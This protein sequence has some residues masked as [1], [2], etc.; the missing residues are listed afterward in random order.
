MD[1]LSS[2]WKGLKPLVQA[3]INRQARNGGATALASS[4]SGGV[5]A[6]ALY[7]VAHTGTL[8]RTQAPWVATDIASA[9]STHS[10]NLAG[11]TQFNYLSLVSANG[12]WSNSSWGK[13]LGMP[14][15]GYGI[16]WP[17]GGATNA[18]NVGATTTGFYFGT[19]TAD[20]NS[21]TPF[22]PL[23]LGN[24][25]NIAINAGSGA[26]IYNRV[27]GSD[28]TALNDTRLMPSG[29][30]LKDL[31]DYNRKWRTLFAAELYVETLVAQS[32][33]ATIGGRI[34][35][36]PT[37][38]L[39]AD[40]NTSQT[41]I[42]TDYSSF[43]SGDY[44]YFATAPGGIAQ[45][46]VMK[47]TSIPSV[48]TG[49][50]RYTVTRNVDASGANSWVAGDA[51]V[52]LGN[53]TSKG[54]IELTSTS[55]IHNHL[56]PTMAIYSRSATTNWNDVKP[57]VAAGN[58][59]SFVDYGADN[60][61]FATGNDLTLT[62]TTGFKGVTIDRAQGVRLFNTN[63][64][65]Y[66]SGNLFLSMNTAGLT[67]VTQPGSTYADNTSILFK[68][69]DGITKILRL[70]GYEN[71]SGGH[72]GSVELNAGTS[73][74]ILHIDSWA[75]SGKFS[76][77]ELSCK[78]G[79]T[80]RQWIFKQLAD[81]TYGA[82]FSGYL[83]TTGNAV[84]G[85]ENSSVDGRLLVN[86]VIEI[87]PQLAQTYRGGIEVD[88]SS[89]Y[90]YSNEYYSGGWQLYNAAKAPAKIQIVSSSADSS[91]GFYTKAANTAQSTLAGN[92]DKNGNFSVTGTIKTTLNTT[93][94]LGGYTVTAPSATGYVTVKIGGTTYK[95]LA[96]T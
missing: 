19:N 49:G 94:D 8:D 77:I 85:N 41:T 58:L 35:V 70:T 61:G 25:G 67:Y 39:I 75:P 18:W 57:V 14:G 33:L 7:G 62:P 20:D 1:S 71:V 46:E 50:Y 34:I 43:L 93:W 73:D 81:G 27:N 37:A 48:I 86:G 79:S 30:I 51:G 44:L 40:V 21:L 53:S 64:A 32:V 88:S 74:T 78:V 68:E 52:S 2:V 63:I 82:D 91:I 76:N 45:V 4:P 26:A 28:V 12:A 84:I 65:Q 10:A 15:Q 66:D 92:F 42:D 55:T 16:F 54:Y 29:S 72:E 31:G 89:T 24:D 9:I 90:I 36:A 56:G 69:S 11:H 23:A 47:V 87:A 95:L 13:A 38:K 5:A 60:M 17:K 83:A 59:R 80:N 6:H 96:S 22:Y 3:E